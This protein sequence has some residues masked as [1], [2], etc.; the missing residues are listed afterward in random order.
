MTSHRFL[1]FSI[2]GNAVLIGILIWQISRPSHQ[3]PPAPTPALSTVH[4]PATTSH[5]FSPPAPSVPGVSHQATLPVPVQPTAAINQA[6]PPVSRDNSLL[7][8]KAGNTNPP[9]RHSPVKSPAAS[10]PMAEASRGASE[11]SPLPQLPPAGAPVSIPSSLPVRSSSPGNSLSHQGQRIT[12][13][14][15]EADSLEISI[16]P[17]PFTPGKNSNSGLSYEDQLFRT[18]WGWQAYDQARAAARASST[19]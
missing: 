14:E 19:P 12:V 13:E 10:S 15:A 4:R 3:Q 16:N 8:T 6:A 5:T 2:I 11:I 7:S 18:K 9:A 1:L 17:D